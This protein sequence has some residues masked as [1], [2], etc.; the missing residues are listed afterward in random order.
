MAERP[1]ILF[2]FPE[3]AD[4]NKKSNRFQ[5]F[6]KPNFSAQYD[7]LSPTFQVLQNAF[8]QKNLMI[9]QS[10]VGINPDFVLV[11]EI[12]GSVDNFYTAVKHCEGMEWMFDIDS[13]DVAS[14]DD[15]FEIKDGQRVESSLKTKLYCVMTNQKAM[16]QILSL[17]ERHNKGEEN[18]FQNGF[19]GLRDVFTHIY[20]IRKWEAKDRFAETGI[21]EY[22]REDLGISGNEPTPFEIEL[23][24]RNDPDKRAI[25]SQTVRKGVIDQG[26]RIL[27]EYVSSDIA[28]HAMIAELPRNVIE[29][30][31]KNYED[32][33]LSQVDDIM[34]FRPTCQAANV[35]LV[36]TE[37]LDD[38]ISNQFESSEAPIAAILDGMPMQ[39]HNLLKD[40]VIV[41][42]PDDYASRYEAK[43]RVHGTEMASL[44]IYGDLGKKERP[45]KRKVYI[46][47]IFKPTLG[48]NDKVY[49][50]IPKEVL[51][52]DVLCRAIRRIKEGENGEPPVAPDV[53][54]INLSI[55]DPFRQL[56]N[57]MSPLA[58]M[59]DFLAYKYKLL[60]II[61]AG[62]H[63]E[64]LNE[65]KL[66]FQDL[67]SKTV[68]Q[69]GDVIWSVIK[70]NQRNLKLLSPAESI[71]GLTVGA[72]YDDYSE[73][74]ENERAIWAVA[75]GMPSPI[76]SFGRG[77]RGIVSPDILYNGGRKFVSTG[78]NT[79]VK[80]AL[81]NTA[82][83]CKVAAPFNNGVESGQMY[84]FGTS[85]SA[86]QITHEAIKCYD[87]LLQIFDDGTGH[88]IPAGYEAILL[89]G[90]ITHGASWE[91]FADELSQITDDSNK[92]LSKWAGNGVP[93]IEKVKECTQNRITLIGYGELKK[94]E[95]HVF[96]LPLHIDFSSKLIKRKL[97]VTLSYF[98]PITTDKQA[99][100]SAQIWFEVDD[101]GKNLITVDGARQNSDWQAVRKGT[102]QHEIFVAEKP[103]VWN[104]EDL[105]IKVNCKEDAGKLKS[106]S[107]PYCIFV[108]F[109]VAE[110]IVDDLYT[111]VKEHILQRVS[112]NNN[113]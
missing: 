4:R 6:H 44:V 14:D 10:T 105:I 95:G 71:N 37:Q 75:K 2:P 65:I 52:V 29:D 106:E 91:S 111:D 39:N 30:L 33:V 94:D 51:F 60:F 100:R 11:F 85:D 61:S 90:M 92:K 73:V 57:S 104:D 81:T 27:K 112:I 50:Q 68:A 77:Y 63:E 72:I 113:T 46:R 15:F 24:Y 49:E 101:G 31:V 56:T 76:S 12:I 74:P 43:C 53:Q 38:G 99:Y 55:G 48:L 89:K 69:R 32:I 59:I 47:P 40:R 82:P 42:D 58:R 109:E 23:F 96:R 79:P 67:K 45:I 13:E 36:N 54:I 110:G 9:Q 102:L 88:N 70:E 3:N 78:H 108:S 41:D 98:S 21:L 86:A 22:W 28:Y 62:N 80:W 16:E 35:S 26:G 97:T 93:D 107:I 84:S 64:V 83:G 7:R 34:F 1:I 8:H 18:V 103:V 87:V 17:W 20:T 19:A 5:S 25:A 66:S